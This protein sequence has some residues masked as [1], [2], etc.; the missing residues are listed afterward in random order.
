MRLMKLIAVMSEPRQMNSPSDD[1][2]Q[3]QSLHNI[4]KTTVVIIELQI[5]DCE[6]EVRLP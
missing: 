2:T 5:S 6:P 4:Q 3:F 1:K